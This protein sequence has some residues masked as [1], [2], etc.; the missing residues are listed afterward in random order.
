MKLK[1]KINGIMQEKLTVKMQP[2]L[3]RWKLPEKYS[4]FQIVRLV[5]QAGFACT[6]KIIKT[7]W[8]F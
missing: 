6:F 3:H 5:N 1:T 8:H 2:K 4:V 7:Q